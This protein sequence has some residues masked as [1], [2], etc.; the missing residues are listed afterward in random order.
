MNVKLVF[1]FNPVRFF[2]Y[3]FLL[4]N[5]LEKEN[6]DKEYLYIKDGREF[7]LLNRFG[8]SGRSGGSPHTL[9]NACARARS[10][11]SHSCQVAMQTATAMIR[12]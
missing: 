3:F 10:S 7:K 12:L 11:V 4:N 8:A 5:A 6:G 9:Q 2:I 1:H